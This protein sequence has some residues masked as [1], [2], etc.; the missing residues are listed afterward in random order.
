MSDLALVGH[1]AKTREEL[2]ANYRHFMRLKLSNELRH[3]IGI[4]EDYDEGLGNCRKCKVGFLTTN[5]GKLKQTF[6]FESF[7]IVEHGF[8]SKTFCS[9]AL[10]S[11]QSQNITRGKS[12]RFEY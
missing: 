6:F 4:Y 1:Q 7:K 8:I 12:E 3:L 5:S 10:C 11:F 9:N 2:I